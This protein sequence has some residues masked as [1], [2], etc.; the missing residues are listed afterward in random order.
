LKFSQCAGYFVLLLWKKKKEENQWFFV[1]GKKTTRKTTGGRGGVGKIPSEE[2]LEKPL[3]CPNLCEQKKR[4]KGD[5]MEMGGKQQVSQGKALI[6][7]GERKMADPSRRGS[8]R[9]LVE[10]F[11]VIRG[12]KLLVAD[13][14]PR[15]GGEL[16]KMS[17]KKK[18]REELGLTRVC[19]KE[20]LSSK[21]GNGSFYKGEGGRGPG[22]L[23]KLGRK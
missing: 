11:P 4:K 22:L 15:I 12:K 16:T 1:R 17:Q 8:D 19:A 13:V 3:S 14:V 9:P 6:L 5:R 20:V 18:D 21:E 7:G 2:I 23:K 10:K